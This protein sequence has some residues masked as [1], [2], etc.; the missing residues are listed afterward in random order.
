MTADPLGGAITVATVADVPD[1]RARRGSP[2]RRAAWLRFILVTAFAVVVLVPVGTVLLLALHP[3]SSGT[4][5]LS[6]WTL[7]AFGILSTTNIPHALLNN[8]MVSV[9]ATVLSVAVGACG[10]YVVSR[11]KGRAVPAYSASLFIIQAL[12]VIVFVIP[13][14]VLFARIALVDSLTGIVI[15]YVAAGVAVNTWIMAAY[16]DTIPVALEEAAWI[17]GCSR[18]G[19]FFRIMLR[20]A[21]PGLLS[22]AVFS[23]LLSWND[24]LAAAVFLKSDDVKT[25]PVAIQQFFQQTGADWASIMASAVLMIIPPLVVFVVLGRRLSLGGL[26]GSLAGK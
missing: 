1:R 15:V 10:G 16:F 6:G 25:M 19:G 3:S 24:Y 9:A 21:T 20:N 23:F 5:D 7:D 17:D 8:L 26:G 13:L 4:S 12:P 11:S 18:F 2:R 14:F 22:A